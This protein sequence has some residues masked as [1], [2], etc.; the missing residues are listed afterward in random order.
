MRR[1]W[2]L[3]LMFILFPASLHAGH[4]YGSVIEN[5]RPLA[6][7]QIQ[8]SCPG[9]SASA[10][11]ASDGSFRVNVGAEGRCTFVLTQYGASAGIFSYAKPTQ[12]DF[13][14]RRQ[15]GGVQLI[16]R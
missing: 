5:G 2:A 3:W 7:A 11:T 15:G 10:Q 8:I 4:I 9:G 14:L 6:N 13:E 12:Y 16:I 1:H